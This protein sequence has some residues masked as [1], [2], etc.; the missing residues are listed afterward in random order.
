MH[1][2]FEFNEHVK[3]GKFASTDVKD[4]QNQTW[5][6]G[7]AIPDSAQSIRKQILV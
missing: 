6:L 1:F 2:Q 7:R 5:Y 3:S 4:S